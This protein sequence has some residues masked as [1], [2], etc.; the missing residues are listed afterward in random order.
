ML[1]SQAPRRSRVLWWRNRVFASVALLAMVFAGSVANPFVG[2]ASATDYPSWADVLAARNSVAAKKAEIAR[3]QKLLAQL[4][5][6]QKTTE[7][8]AIEKGRIYAE[9]QD[10]FDQQDS[11]TK[12]YQAQADAAQA[13]ADDS[14]KRAGQLAARMSRSSGTDLTATL[15]FNGDNAR[16]LLAQV[17]M[18]AK[19]TDQS[20]GLYDRATQDQKTAQSL[21]DQANVAKAALEVLRDAAQ[22][23]QVEAQAAADAAAAA[24]KEQQ[25]NNATLQAQLATLQSNQIHTEA[26]YVKGVQAQWGA[27]DGVVEISSQGWAR[28]AF[29]RITDGFGPRVAPIPGVL[30]FH[31]G[32]DI[33]A[34]CNSSIYAAQ[35]GTVIYAGWYG[36]YGNFVLIDH[37]S[38][39]STGYAHIVSGGIKVHYGQEVVVGQVIAKVGSTGASTGCHLHFEVREW[40]SAVNPVPFMAARGINLR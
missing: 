31:H 6:N 23:A 29:G 39:I 8:A 25:D 5:T 20:Q 32:V 4:E 18:A 2:A 34:S 33:A 1:R 9:A 7:A 12:E 15:F 19:I 30:P 27:G 10:A 40:G 14:I 36:T 38:G 3:I 37:G 22:K 26:E 13:K 21:T 24:L 16:N 17:G 11:K 28:P 35:S